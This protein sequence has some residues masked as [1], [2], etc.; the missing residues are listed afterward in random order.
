M[1]ELT[2]IKPEQAFIDS[3]EYEVGT[4]SGFISKPSA[5]MC[6]NVAFLD[7]REDRVSGAIMPAYPTLA[8]KVDLEVIYQWLLALYF[9]IWRFGLLTKK[10]CIYSLCRLICL[11]HASMRLCSS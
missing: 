9:L 10:L 8:G 1:P 11:S 6:G 7:I 5:A 3:A 4:R 2:E